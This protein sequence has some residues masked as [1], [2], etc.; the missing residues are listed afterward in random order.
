MNPADTTVVFTTLAMNQ[1]LFFAALGETFKARGYKVAHIAFHERSHEYLTA[2]GE[3]VY[4]A[5]APKP[6]YVQSVD[7][8]RYSWPSL[9]LILSH[10]KAAF[11]IN[12]SACLIRKLRGYLA[13]MEQVFDELQGES[14]RVILVQE[15][16]G[17]LSII[18]AF[19][20][21]RARGID[22]MF[23]EPSFFRGRVFFVKNSL[24]AMPIP[25]PASPAV[26]A[27]VSDYLN[28][29][30][31]NQSVVIPTKDLY[32]YRAA[33]KKILDPYNMRRFAEKFVDKYVMGR[34][35]EFGHIGGHVARHL[36]M[37]VN[38][39]SLRRFYRPLPQEFFI[40]YP[41]HVPADVALTLR[42]PEYLDQ[43]ALVD[44]LCR[45]AP[46]PCK[47]AIKEHPA[48]VGAVNY[49]RIR[50]LLRRHDN[51]VLLDAGLNNYEVLRTARVVVTVNSK[52]GAE[53]LLLSKPVV[54]LGNAFYRP[55]RLV[56]AIDNQ[57]DLPDMLAQ[58]TRQ[59]PVLSHYDVARY[60]QDVWDRSYPG[61]L[62]V[63]ASDNVAQFARSLMAFMVESCIT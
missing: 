29:T 17:F 11:E 32:H 27:E 61:E 21:A 44:F 36:R 26:S 16:G 24:S 51:L 2:R 14:G 35:E 59:P 30:I 52:S 10:E 9:N 43:Y 33:A 19:Y 7:L 57:H 58:L 12:D 48:L 1:T 60:F 41:L 20:A 39:Q 47:V 49:R 42:S 25:G 62:Y 3:R 6:D 50:D 8:Q 34:R 46:H 22:N 18:A 5:F 23:L 37:A 4:N 40:Y 55:C 63:A 31:R 56:H 15:L 54:V 13:A 28:R 53:A 38:S 45:A